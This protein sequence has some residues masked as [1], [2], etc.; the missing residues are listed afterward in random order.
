MDLAFLPKACFRHQYRQVFW[1]TPL[2]TTFPPRIFSGQWFYEGSKAVGAYSSGDC[3]GL[4]QK[5]RGT[6]FPF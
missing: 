2:L 6:G 4:S 5:F 1:L 3:S